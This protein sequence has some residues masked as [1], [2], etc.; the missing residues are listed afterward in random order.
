MDLDGEQLT[1]LFT[2]V[3]YRTLHLPTVVAEELLQ[4]V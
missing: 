4:A 2:D 3:G 1:V